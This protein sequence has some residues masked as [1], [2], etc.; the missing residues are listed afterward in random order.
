MLSELGL[1]YR[2]IFLAFGGGPNGMK[3][4]AY[5][6]INPNG[7]IP[8]I[9]DHSNGDFVVWESGA[10]ITYICKKYDSEF[11]LWGRTIEEQA[12]IETWLHFQVSGQGPYLGQVRAFRP[13]SK[14]CGADRVVLQA[15]F[16]GIYHT[17]KIP[18]VIGRYIAESRR[19]LGVVQKQL[20]KENSN[21]WLVLGRIT[22][23]DIAFFQW[24]LHAGRVGIRIAEEFPAVY[25][26][27]SK[28]QARPGVIKGMAGSTVPA[29]VRGD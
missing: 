23:A 17:E 4:P 24:W 6:A 12:Q 8:A 15:L 29:E 16:F 11:K 5:E 20:E 9:V 18:F 1:E 2:T 3:T 28:I 13:C 7:R 21:G 10:I 27:M 19:V 25:E 26:W 22:V 14:L